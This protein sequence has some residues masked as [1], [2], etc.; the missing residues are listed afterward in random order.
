MARHRRTRR[1]L[2]KQRK[3]II[4]SI[5]CFMFLMVG[6]YSA[7]QTN[8]N[9][10]AKG[11]I[12]EKSRVIQSW[13]GN[14]Q[15]DFHSDYYKE[16]IVSATFL[17]NANVTSN[18][19][20]S[21]NVSEDKEHGGVMAWVVPNNED[22]TK[23]DLYIGANDGVIANEDSSNLFREF[24][25]LNIVKFNNF[26]TSNA[27][28]MNSLFNTYNTQSGIVLEGHLTTIDF[29]EKFDTSKVTDMAAMFQGHRSLK[30]IDLSDFDTSN[31]A[32][33]LHMFEYTGITTLDLSSFDTSNVTDMTEMF[34]RMSNLISIN[35]G[36]KFY[37]DKVLDMQGMFNQCTS[38]IELN[39]CSFDTRNVLDMNSM[40]RDTVDLENIR[41][42]PNWTTTNANITD[43]FTG[44][45]VS[46]V[47]T[48]Q[49]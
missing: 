29:G 35:F 39:L 20:E 16:N 1:Q 24:V 34:A 37:T 22:N 7:F 4:I 25:A 31:V 12:K 21:W 3:I 11:N 36:N 33:M 38:L 49:C 9:I 48:G 42:G 23:Y 13:T 30:E 41:V 26:D 14:D 15:T 2:K 10:T 8:L 27:T 46:S 19:I 17:D 44:S 18:A 43:M 32:N 47:T 6:G 5:I 45:S 40:F 28:T